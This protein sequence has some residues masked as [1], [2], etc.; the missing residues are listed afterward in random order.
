MDGRPASRE[1]LRLRLQARRVASITLVL[2][3][4]VSVGLL[5]TF[6]SGDGVGHNGS[7]SR[8]RGPSMVLRS[9][10]ESLTASG[11]NSHLAVKHW[12]T[13][14]QATYPTYKAEGVALSA[15]P[16]NYTPPLTSAEV[17]SELSGYALAKSILGSQLQSISPAVT[18]AEVT[19]SE[20]TLPGV[21]AGVGYPAWVI[22]FAGT[23]PM[24][25]GTAPNPPPANQTCTTV[26]IYDL[27]ASAWSTAFQNC[28]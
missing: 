1:G 17:V 25:F 12:R 23:K 7:V 6:I 18:L 13:R 28:S 22:S 26:V 15:P 10:L 11:E 27:A 16:A 19:E 20:P 4:C 2:L 9:H 5:L 24:W 3:T 14:S 8:I 21:A